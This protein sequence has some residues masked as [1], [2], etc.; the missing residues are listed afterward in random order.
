MSKLYSDEHPEKSLQNT[1]FKNKTMA[2]QT[3]SLIKKRSLHYQF[4]V[5]NTMYYRAKNH[6]NKTKQM[7]DAMKIYKEWLDKYPIKKEKDDNTQLTLDKIRMIEKKIDKNTINI[8]KK[9]SK[10][11][12]KL[13]FI[14]YP[15]NPKYDY[16][17]YLLYILKKSH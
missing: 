4:T 16:Y 10:Q 13:K 12:W 3:L 11:L 15:E 2:K 14:I 8:I 9:N 6:P 1:G 5:V 7:E 17:S